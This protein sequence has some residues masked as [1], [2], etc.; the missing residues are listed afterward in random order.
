MIHN[1]RQ[2]R[3]E[4]RVAYEQ[5]LRSCL[6]IDLQQDEKKLSSLA[7]DFAKSSH[8]LQSQVT[9]FKERIAGSPLSAM[10][11]LWGERVSNDKIFGKSYLK[12]MRDL[13]ET[14]LLPL[15]VK[16][17]KTGTLQDLLSQD[18]SGIVDAIRC[19]QDWSINR[20]EDAVLVYIAF[21]KW[22]SKETF[23]YVPEANDLDRISTQK[24]A[25]LFETYLKIV[26]HLDLREQILA[27]MFYLGGQRALEEVL[28]VKIEDVNF[29]RFLIHF[30]EDVSY[31]GHLF[32]DIKRFIQG[33][34]NGYVFAGKE[35]ERVSTTTPFRALK[36]VV[37]KLG[38]DPE[39]TFK[40]FTKN[41]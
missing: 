8:D 3:S 10:V 25:I 16:K 14:G 5:L 18:S 24:R 23:G 11:L 6:S 34:K 1:G 7:S 4:E 26:S 29:S 17:K 22:L 13:V 12:I 9:A 38:L 37:A 2:E 36:R 40:E 20:R 21:S 39:F 35:E 31:P 15:T 32:E 30:S 19:H 33:R 41:I 27:K 28:S